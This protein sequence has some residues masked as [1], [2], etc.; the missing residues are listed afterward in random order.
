MKQE[1]YLFRSLQWRFMLTHALAALIAAYCFFMSIAVLSDVAYTWIEQPKER[2]QTILTYLIGLEADAVLYIEHDQE[3]D[4]SRLRAERSAVSN[5]LRV[6][7]SPIRIIP[8]MLI[9]LYA[10]ATGFAIMMHQGLLLGIVLSLLIYACIFCVFLCACLT[11]N[12]LSRLQSLMIAADHWGRGEFAFT[13]QD[14]AGDELAELT[15]HF[16]SMARQLQVLF[17]ERQDYTASEER[18]Y[19]ARDLHDSVKQQFY[20]LAA[21]IQVAKELYLQPYR[22]QTHLQEATLLLQSIQEE[23]NNVIQHL[24]PTALVEKGLKSAMQDHLQ[25]WGR[26]H[27]IRTNFICD[28]QRSGG[29]VALEQEEEKALF[30]V[31][32][33]ALSNVARHSGALYVEVHLSSN[34]QEIVLSILDNGHGF[35]PEGVV[36]GIGTHSMRERLEVLGGTVEI[37]SVAGQ[38]TTVVASLKEMRKTDQL[39]PVQRSLVLSTRCTID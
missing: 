26:L 14:E 37:R 6:G 36:L 23:M 25:S 8:S 11:G 12:F 18:N 1:K 31:M 30:R 17:T 35:D 22:A 3:Q 10:I 28:L 34:S 5:H 2:Q 38:G 15:H 7:V 16:N 24:R 33:E 9:G 20:A 21:Q 4:Q 19:L 29:V 32:Q 39:A 27:G 13:V